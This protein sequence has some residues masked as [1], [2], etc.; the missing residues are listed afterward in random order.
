MLY[1]TCTYIQFSDAVNSYCQ[2]NKGAY[3]SMVPQLKEKKNTDEIS[4]WEAAHFPVLVRH[5]GRKRPD[6]VGH[7]H[8]CGTRVGSSVTLKIGREHGPDTCFLPMQPRRERRWKSN[9]RGSFGRR[10]LS[11]EAKFV[12]TAAPRWA[13]GRRFTGCPAATDRR[14]KSRPAAFHCQEKK[15]KNIIAIT[16]S[17][18]ILEILS[19]QIKYGVINECVREKVEFHH[20]SCSSKDMLRYF[21]T[22]I[23]TWGFLSTCLISHKTHINLAGFSSQSQS[24]IFDQPDWSILSLSIGSNAWSNCSRIYFN[25]SWFRALWDL[26]VATSRSTTRLSLSTWGS[27]TG[28]RLFVDGE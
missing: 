2:R 26:V 9:V 8:S 20:S 28:V 6:F 10:E 7:L 18:N 12:D 14:V 5:T 25:S 23:G 13:H 21:Q 4:R 24:Y 3:W 1:S 16:I 22:G 15:R 19:H 17:M 11:G 27:S